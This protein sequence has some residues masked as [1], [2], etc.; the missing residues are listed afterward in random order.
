MQ[1]RNHKFRL[2]SSAFGV[3]A[4]GVSLALVLTA[5]TSSSGTKSASTG[6]SP[7][8]IKIGLAM[9]TQMQRRWGFDVASMQEECKAL[10]ADCIIQYA[11]DD[12]TKQASQVENLLSQGIDVMVL[13]PVDGKA[14]VALVAAAHAQHVPV[15]DYDEFIPGSDFFVTRD[16][17]AVGTAQAEAALKFS[18][19]GKW[20]LIKGDA[21]NPVAQE[22]DAAYKTALAGKS[23][24]I[25]YNQFTK[26]W[27]PATAQTKAENI[28]SAN[29]DNI[30]VFLTSNDGM[31]TGVAQA[32][33]GRN[34][35]GKVFV[36]G[37]DADP[38]NLKLIAAGEQI[39][40]VW[41]KLDVWG[42]TSIDVAVALANK[43]VPKSDTTTQGVPTVLIPI[44]E[45]NKA[46]L[47]DFITNS[48]P[49]AWATV[50]DVYGR[51]TC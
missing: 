27:D 34:L 45:V 42:K 30:K 33:K 36:S 6:S 5:C 44:Q 25:V 4:I 31:A 16:N 22:I 1:P 20:A 40:T 15:V 43:Q 10:N 18:P 48:A 21:G 13:V 38:T 26:N 28:L 24:Q 11:N 37:L 14:G 35:S 23:M 8:R 9:K 29:G 50:Q 2:Q 12:A 51:A 47:C 49:K 39:M 46:N 17:A 3:C 41:T 32:L 19:T 7:K